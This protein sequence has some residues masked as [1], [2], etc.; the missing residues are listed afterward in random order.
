MADN[1]DQGAIIT[2]RHENDLPILTAKDTATYAEISLAALTLYS[3]YWLHQWELRRT[4]EAV[5]V[6]NWRLFPEK[7]AMI[8][9]PQ[10]PD[11]F[12]TNRSLLQGQPKYR[13]WLTGSAK[14]GFSLNERGID[15]ARELIDKLGPPLT[16]TGQMVTG[17]GHQPKFQPISGQARSI[18]PGRE[19]QRLRESRL[20]G[21]WKAGL[22]AERDLVHVHSLLGVFD[23]TPESVREKK[24]KDLERSAGDLADIEV[25]Q[26]LA[27]VRGQFPLV[28]ATRSQKGGRNV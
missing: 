16:S 11:A 28:F 20:F 13:N 10:Y 24:M 9:W 21:K 25:G 23:H 19:I 2:I 18:E 17:T 12:R 14:R 3:L 7:F 5:T 26:F 27:D 6:V 15:I 1:S 22:L 8:G 4:I